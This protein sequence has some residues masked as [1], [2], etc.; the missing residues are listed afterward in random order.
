MYVIKT[1]HKIV[2]YIF[3]CLNLLQRAMDQKFTLVALL[4][5]IQSTKI[6]LKLTIYKQILLLTNVFVLFH[7]R[8][9]SVYLEVH[10]R[11]YLHF[12]FPQME[13]GMC[14]LV[15]KSWL[16]FALQLAFKWDLDVL[17]TILFL[18]DIYT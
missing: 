17:S 11:N 6:L 14:P 15:L 10:L 13:V 3:I 16:C 1:Y 7:A 18:D 2:I 8:P 12:A 5:E 9:V 4:F